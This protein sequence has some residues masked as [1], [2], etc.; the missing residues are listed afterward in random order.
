MIPPSWSLIKWLYRK[1]TSEGSSLWTSVKV[2]LTSSLLVRSTSSSC[3]FHDFKTW[4]N[5]SISSPSASGSWSALLNV[6]DTAR[7]VEVI[8]NLT[9]LE[10][11]SLPSADQPP[12]M[13][14]SDRLKFRT[15]VAVGT[16]FRPRWGVKSC[17]ELVRKKS[18]TPRKRQK[19]E[20]ESGQRTPSCTSFPCS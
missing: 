9:A 2:R 6:A 1:G 16:K 18:L 11:R 13:S 5:R 12:S 4:P 17:P 14:R 7:C 8:L 20:F 3:T 19:Q 15:A 10:Y